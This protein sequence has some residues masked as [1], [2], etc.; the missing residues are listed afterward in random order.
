MD[1]NGK[2]CVK[3]ITLSEILHSALQMRDNT[4][5]VLCDVTKHVVY[6]K[7][8]FIMSVH[9]YLQ[10]YGPTWVAAFNSSYSPSSPTMIS[11]LVWLGSLCHLGEAL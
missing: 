2:C 1:E 10:T 7:V 3:K 8:I 11:L 9:L 4:L 6:C 5:K